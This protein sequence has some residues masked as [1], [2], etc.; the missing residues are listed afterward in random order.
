MKESAI[1]LD[2]RL[3]LGSELG[4]A[5]WR[6]NVGSLEV[7]RPSGRVERVTYGLCTGS[8]DLIGIAPGG[9][10][11]SLEIKQPGKYPTKEQRLFAELVKQ[12]GG[13]A[14]TV[15]SPQEALEIVRGARER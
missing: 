7:L 2:V 12:L 6:N 8:G 13:I 1:Q 10:F 15:R 3:A 5:F 4:C 11:C 14:G 9:L